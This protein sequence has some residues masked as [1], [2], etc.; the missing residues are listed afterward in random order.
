MASNLVN[1][2][3]GTTNVIPPTGLTFICNNNIGD[4]YDFYI[5]GNTGGT[6]STFQRSGRLPAGNIFSTNANINILNNGPNGI[7]YYHAPE[8]APTT[9]F[10]VTLKPMTL[11]NTCPSHYGGNGSPIGLTTDQMN[12]KELEFANGYSDYNCVKNLYES[13]KDGGNTPAQVSEIESSWPPEM[14]E[15]RTKLLGESPHLTQEALRSASVKTDVFPESILFEILSANADEMR[16]GNLLEFL[17]TKPQPLDEYSIEQLREIG[18]S[19]TYKTL[20]QNDLVEYDRKKTIAANDILRSALN[21]DTLECDLI[22]NWLDNNGSL[23]SHYQIVDSWLQS[24]DAGAA[25]SMINAI[26]LLHPLTSSENEEYNYFKTLKELQIGVIN[27]GRNMMELDENEKNQLAA[28]ADASNEIAGAQ[29][30]GLLEFAYGYEYCHCNPPDVTLKS[31][32]ANFTNKSISS[33]D[34]I[35]SV[36][37][38]PGSTW[39]AFD[40]ILPASVQSIELKIS[41]GLGKTMETIILSEKH[42]QKILDTHNYASGTYYYLIQSSAIKESGSFIIK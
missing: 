26:P 25:T 41:D 9:Y 28:I 22:R 18:K 19:T 34:L 16:D 3:N 1:G 2:V 35:L 8:Q 12:Q 17:G 37:P 24:A 38:N 7:F 36:S 14:W 4:R 21:S 13:L 29:A 32:P 33:K 20:L 6:I 15:L 11:I 5:N 27:S 23:N 42:G 31:S 39:I 10:G 40:Y 30:K